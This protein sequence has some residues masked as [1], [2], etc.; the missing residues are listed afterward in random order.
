MAFKDKYWKTNVETFFSYQGKKYMGQW[1]TFREMMEISEERFPDNEAFKAIVPKV[2]TFTYK[3]ALKKIRE[4]AYYLIASGAKKGDHIAV[5]GKNS[6]EWALAYFAISFAGCIIVPL[7][8]SLHIEDMEKILAFGDVDRIFIDGEKIDEIDKEGKLFKEK[9]SLEPES[10]GHKYVLDLTGPETELPKL[11]AEDTAAMLFTSGTT[12]TPKGVM[13]SFSNFMSSALSSQ[14]LFDVYPTDV[15]Y[16]ILPIHHAYTMTAVLLETVIS[17]ASCVFG[18]RL[19]TPIMLKELREG[20][21]TMLLAVPMLFNK[22]LAGLMAGVHKQGP[23]KENLIRFLMGFSGFMKKVFHVNLGKKIFGNMLLSKIS[24]DKMRL[25]ICGG[26]PLPPSTFKQFN[27]LGID[28]VQGYGLTETSPIIN[29]NPIEVY[30]EESVG[31]PIPG[32]EE[33]IV[34]PDE[35][36]NGIIYVRGPQVMKGYYKNDEAT[37]EVLSSDGWLN[38][39]DVGH[40][41]SN[42]FLYLTGR[43]KSIIV[44]EGGK[45]VFPEEIE[46]KFQLFNEIEQCCIIPYMINKE[47]KTEGIRMVIYPTEAYL[48]EHGMEETSRHM[49]E[50]V[51]SVNKGLQSYKKITMV[52]VVDQPL[53]MT[54]T[55][56][57]KRF[58]VVK[59]FK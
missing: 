32:V 57:V 55:K 33:K 31:I 30:I 9:I 56:K 49:E 16:A 7:D 4:I 18:K 14:R 48:K 29:I 46:D 1:P 43:A 47:M 35:D 44:T 39:G 42:G 36:G 3:E 6:P 54:S 17:G 20:K 50:V 52:T 11:H 15:F 13:L 8:Y 12:G 53:P 45:N 37:E 25:C 51:E 2:V 59:M 23:F 41:D 58:E 21:I 10:K 5:I 40:I 38:T 34:S 24:L 27:Q 28:F 22:L 26:G 19:V